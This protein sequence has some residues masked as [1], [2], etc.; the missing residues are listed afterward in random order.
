MQI[1]VTKKLIFLFLMTQLAH[2]VII[3]YR[4]IRRLKMIHAFVNIKAERHSINEV[5]QKLLEI[6]GV[7]EVYSVTG[8]HDIIAVLRV[9]SHEQISKVVTEEILN[10]KNIISS[11]TVIAFK[12]YSKKDL[13][14][15]W[16]IGFEE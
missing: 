16:S 1:I 8:D 10:I 11:K 14:K 2:N 7:S 5:T 4:K 6:K 9:N 15:M 13:E 12:A 3:F